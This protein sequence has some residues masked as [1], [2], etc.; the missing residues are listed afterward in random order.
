MNSGALPKH[1][2]SWVALI[3]AGILVA[4]ASLVFDAVRFDLIASG[5]FFS[6]I[7]WVLLSLAD[8]PFAYALLSLGAGISSIRPREA[9][10]KSL[11][12][13]GFAL[14][15][16]YALSLVLELR[17]QDAIGNFLFQAVFWCLAA[18]VISVTMAPLACKMTDKSYPYKQAAA[19]VVASLL[20]APYWYMLLTTYSDGLFYISL[21]V[22]ALIPILFLLYRLR[23]KNYLHLVLSVLI[24]SILC[25]VGMLVIYQLS[26]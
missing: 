8:G 17:P 18:V 5:D 7:I 15:S 12:S 13:L 1:R 22:C 16:Y 3:I 11:V 25:V 6:A 24:T 26:Y 21:L 4:I 2:F 10:V 20:G 19:G 9:I 14:F 23:Y